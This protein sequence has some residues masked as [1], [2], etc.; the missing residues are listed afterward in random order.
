MLRFISTKHFARSRKKF[1][2]ITP[3]SATKCQQTDDSLITSLQ[4]ICNTKQTREVSENK[5]DI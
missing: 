4:L 5:A 1:F 2:V 3:G